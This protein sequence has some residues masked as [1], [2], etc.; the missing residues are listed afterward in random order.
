M[1]SHDVN[2]S[3]V[4]PLVSSRAPPPKVVVAVPEILSVVVVALVVVE[5]VTRSSLMV[6]LAVETKPPVK[7]MRVEVETPPMST[8]T[9]NGKV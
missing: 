7:P 8:A 1:V 3:M 5:F 9:S 6:V 2:P 4:N